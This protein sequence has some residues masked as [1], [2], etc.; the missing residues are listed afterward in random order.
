MEQV[1]P[2]DLWVV[3]FIVGLVWLERCPGNESLD[4]GRRRAQNKISINS[5]SGVCRFLSLSLLCLVKVLPLGWYCVLV[6][7]WRLKGV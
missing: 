3:G 4:Q 5:E 1:F 6:N 7:L 2:M